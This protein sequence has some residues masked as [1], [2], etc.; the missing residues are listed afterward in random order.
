MA[1]LGLRGFNLR[2]FDHGP[3]LEQAWANAHDGLGEERLYA[4]AAET[5]T[6]AYYNNEKCIK[7]K[8]IAVSV[9]VRLLLLEFACSALA[10]LVLALA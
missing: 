5:Y 2:D 8:E 6:N 1:V 10:V 9:G 7:P 4:W 3:L